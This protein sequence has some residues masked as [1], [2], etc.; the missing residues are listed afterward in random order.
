MDITEVISSGI[1]NGLWIPN[2]T[3]NPK[4]IVSKMTA[5]TH[6]NRPRNSSG[7]HGFRSPFLALC[8]RKFSRRSRALESFCTSAW[9]RIFSTESGSNCLPSDA[10]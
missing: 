10:A 6:G 8:A 7:T 1:S 9:S 4:E 3:M 2:C 5:G